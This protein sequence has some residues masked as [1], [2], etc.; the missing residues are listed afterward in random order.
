MTELTELSR[1]HAALLQLARSQA[2]QGDNLIQ[3]LRQITEIAARALGVARASVWLS[4]VEH[5]RIRCID[6]YEPTLGRHCD[7]MEL[8]FRDHPAYFRALELQRVIVAH[9]ARADPR[10]RD[11][12]ATYLVPRGITSMLDVAVRQRGAFRGVVCVEHVGPTRRWSVQEEVLVCAFADLVTLALEASE[13]QLAE[14]ALAEREERFG[15]VFRNS[16][17]PMA[18]YAVGSRGR[19]TLEDINPAGERFLNRAA[20]EVIGRGPQ[21]FMPTEDIQMVLR[22]FR[23]AV[24][25]GQPDASQSCLHMPQGPRWVEVLIVPSRRPGQRVHRLAVLLRDV[26]ESVTYQQAILD[27]E[28]EVRRLNATL[29]RRVQERTAQLDAANKELEAFSYSVSHDLR[30]PLRAIDGFSKALL[31]D[32]PDKLDAAGHDMLLRVRAASQRMGELIDDLLLLSR[33][34]RTEMRSEAV[35]LSR[36][37]EDVAAQLARESPQRRVEWHIQPGLRVQGDPALVRVLLENLLGNAWKYTSKRTLARIAFGRNDRGEFYVQDNG[38]GFDA[39]YSAKLFQPFQRLHRLDEFEGHGIGLAT[40]QRVVT[41][42]GGAVRGEGAPDQGAT[43]YFTL[44]AVEGEA[45]G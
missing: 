33:I 43:F 41:R 2:F 16:T 20:A 11:Y 34:S 30:A 1:A 21:E 36:L 24:D 23:R 4:D 35:P 6:L 15:E 39:A 40:V 19:F 42:H 32:Y 3:D 38:A 12:A 31:E 37:A 17:N 25:S 7:G 22:A 44:P 29:E 8:L 26:T 18:F 10:T 28:E 45:H 5:S 14:H 9:D 27:R 13:R